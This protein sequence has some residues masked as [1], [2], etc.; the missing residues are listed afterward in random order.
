MYLFERPSVR[1]KM[2]NFLPDPKGAPAN[3]QKKTCAN[4]V[5]GCDQFK[6][7]SPTAAV[8]RSW[9]SL[10]SVLPFTSPARSRA[11]SHSRKQ[12]KKIVLMVFILPDL[13]DSLD[14]QA[15]VL[16]G[17]REQE[18]MPFLIWICLLLSYNCM[19]CS[20]FQRWKPSPT[21]VNCKIN[22]AFSRTRISLYALKHWGAGSRKV[23]AWRRK[24]KKPPKHP[25]KRDKLY[26][27]RLHY[28]WLVWKD[29]SLFIGSL[30][31]QIKY[32]IRA[33]TY[34]TEM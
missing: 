10:G 16:A 28:A 11:A 1:S 23:N 3:R 8:P 32:V 30:L 9:P 6:L 14:T 33:I 15:L 13:A 12:T 5:W 34:K 17:G 7:I 31:L 29:M 20:K 24:E 22:I 21:D 27:F 26:Y 19:I 2:P 18:N 25:N 4:R